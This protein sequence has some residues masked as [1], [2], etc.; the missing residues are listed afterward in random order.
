MEGMLART[1]VGSAARELLR[2]LFRHQCI[3]LDDE[4]VQALSGPQTSAGLT[5]LA[6]EVL[7]VAEVFP[8]WLMHAELDFSSPTATSS[9]FSCLTATAPRAERQN[10]A[11]FLVAHLR[12]VKEGGDSD[13]FRTLSEFVL[14]RGDPGMAASVVSEVVKFACN[15]A[16]AL[17]SLRNVVDKYRSEESFRSTVSGVVAHQLSASLKKPTNVLVALTETFVAIEPSPDAMVERLFAWV[18]QT[19]LSPPKARRTELL[20]LALKL[21]GVLSAFAIALSVAGQAVETMMDGEDDDVRVQC[22]SSCLS[23]CAHHVRADADENRLNSVV[24]KVVTKLL[25]T[26][27]AD[28]NDDVRRTVL[29]ALHSN[30]QLDSH[31]VLPDPLEC[32]FMAVHDSDAMVSE[33]ALGICCRLAARNPSIVVPALGRVELRLMRDL[34]GGV[35][36]MSV[37]AVRQLRVM[38]Q[39]NRVVTAAHVVESE[40]FDKFGR[41]ATFGLQCHLFGLIST[42][43]QNA[44]PSD[45]HIDADALVSRC[46]STVKNPVSVARRC[47]ASAALACVVR[48][49]P[50]DSQ[51]DVFRAAID[52]VKST[53][54]EDGSVLD[55]LSQVVAVIGAVDPSR[56]RQWELTAL[57]SQ[58]E[59]PTDR[60]ELESLRPPS[61][62]HPKLAFQNASVSLFTLVKCMRGSSTFQQR[63]LVLSIGELIEAVGAQQKAQLAPHLLPCLL[64]WLDANQNKPLHASIL[65][66]L[67]S[68]WEQREGFA[69]QLR[70]QL[71]DSLERYSRTVDLNNRHTVEHFILLL[72]QIVRGAPDDVLAHRW[73]A[74]F[75]LQRLSEN[76]DGEIAARA[77]DALEASAVMLGNDLHFTLTQ[78]L[79]CLRSTSAIVINRTLGFLSAVV[80]TQTAKDLCARTIHEVLHMLERQENNAEVD[81][82][83]VAYLCSLLHSVGK[84]AHRFVGLIERTIAA[85]GKS[86]ERFAQFVES[87]RTNNVFP[88]P[89]RYR[90]PTEQAHVVEKSGYFVLQSR[91]TVTEDFVKSC[92]AEVLSV[93][94]SNIVVADCRDLG[95]KG[96]Y[97]RFR[98]DG[99]AP[100]VTQQL[101]NAINRGHTAFAASLQVASFST[102]STALSTKSDV[103]TTMMKLRAWQRL[104]ENAAAQ[105]W[106]SWLV[107]VAVELVKCSEPALRV[108]LAVVRNNEIVA[109]EIFPFAF[110]WMFST[111]DAAHKREAMA[112]LTGA[113]EKCSAEVRQILFSLAEFMESEKAERVITQKNILSKRINVVRQSL[114]DK[115]GIHYERDNTNIMVVKV[116]ENGP[117]GLAKVPVGYALKSIDGTE[118]HDVH[119]IVSLI[120]SRL[121]TTLELQKEQEER[122]VSSRHNEFFNLDTLATVAQQTHLYAKALHYSEMCF[123]ELCEAVAANRREIVQVAD[124]ITNLCTIVGM[125][126]EFHGILR[127]T[128]ETLD[129]DSLMLDGRGALESW[130][131][132]EPASTQATTQLNQIYSAIRK[133]ETVGDFHNIRGV[134]R[135]RKYLSEDIATCCANAAIALSDWGVLGDV[136]TLMRNGPER[137]VATCVLSIARNDA[138]DA[139]RKLI[140]DCR[141]QLSSKFA[142]EVSESYSAAYDSIV[143]LQHLS[144]LEEVIQYK[145]APDGVKQRLHDLWRRRTHGMVRRVQN[146]TVAM[147]INSLV[148][149]P[150][151]DVD[152]LLRYVSLCREAQWSFMAKFTL[153][154]LLKVDNGEQLSVTSITDQTPPRVAMAAFKHLSHG[155]S[156]S[157]SALRA[158]EG[159]VKGS[160]REHFADDPSWC[161][162]YLHLGERF[163]NKGASEEALAFV[164]KA[165]EVDPSNV[166][167]WHAW[168][169]LNYRR[170]H[171]IRDA[172]GVPQVELFV[173]CLEGLLRAI[174]LGEERLGTQDVLRIMSVWFDYGHRAEVLLA[175]EHGIQRSPLAVW[176]R[177][178]PQLIARLGVARRNVRDSLIALVHRVT[179]AFPHAMIYPLTVSQ[180]SA[181]D[182]LRA[183]AAGVALAQIREAW[184]ALVDQA[185]LISAEL[186]RI[187]ILWSEKWS[188]A[189]TRA[190]RM[191]DRHDSRIVLDALAPL[192][193]ELDHPLTS[194]EKAFESH[195]GQTL[196]RAKIALENEPTANQA[197]QFFQQVYTKFN[198]PPRALQLAQVSPKLADL[199]NSVMP[200]PGLVTKEHDVTIATFAQDIVVIPSKHK[201][202]RFSIIASNGVEHRYLLKGHEDLRQDE[203]VMQLFELIN[204]VF[205]SD[206]SSDSM[207]LFVERYAA[208]P[209]SDNV[210]ILGWIDDSE[211]LFKLIDS[212]RNA[213]DIPMLE[214]CNLIMKRGRLNRIDEY[215]GLPKQ[216]RRELLEYVMG[217]TP[218][219]QLRR[220][221][222]DNND[223]CEMWLQYRSTY[224]RSL[225]VMSMVGYVLGLG[226][227]HL[228]NLMIKKNGAIVHID[229]GDC[230]ETAM[231]RE[232]FPEAVPFRLTRMLVRAL[233]VIGV[234]GAYRLTSEHVMRQLRK[235]RDSLQSVLET[236][237]HDPL[238]PWKGV[239][240]RRA[241]TEEMQRQQSSTEQA[242]QW[243]AM[244]E[245][246]LKAPPIEAPAAPLPARHQRK[247]SRGFSPGQSLQSPQSIDG[248]S[249]DVR[250]AQVHAALNHAMAD[251][252]VEAATQIVQRSRSLF[253]QDVRLSNEQGTELRSVDTLVQYFLHSSADVNRDRENA[254]LQRIQSKLTGTDFAELDEMQ[255]SQRRA[256]IPKNDSVEDRVFEMMH[257]F[258]DVIFHR[259]SVG[260]SLN[261]QYTAAGVTRQSPGCSQSNADVLPVDVQVERLISAAR[262]LDNL[263]DAFLTGWAPFL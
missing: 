206:P 104:G 75:A 191:H 23:V 11:S 20:A 204:T 76:R 194:D 79:P 1:D 84:A 234:E 116:A 51:A 235:Y 196:K 39:A 98:I 82:R 246:A 22:A 109:R 217:V 222:W 105:E 253:L 38:A 215:Q 140:R 247:A 117:G 28:P 14:Q 151:D 111:L 45:R 188:D 149:R 97:V 132:K 43:I 107:S 42:T 241:H 212:W 258:D 86:S 30:K 254:I 162:C 60:T 225:A 37:N 169:M 88:E 89:Q 158:F 237:V 172:G 260:T 141:R 119:E 63:S 249:H 94:S 67:K 200:I 190:S 72:E 24:L 17:V 47:A 6:A 142:S 19:L 229:F 127:F 4:H 208:V 56:V 198:R 8:S 138:P 263:A 214:E 74:G 228:N 59:L 10:V 121:S 16:V 34:H 187:A 44:K 125:P 35:L 13:L 40:C 239:V 166:A 27:V 248:V 112:H 78:V 232:Q 220:V 70:Q 124:R 148:L 95:G 167:G 128:R 145:S 102:D 53:S 49:L 144:H 244:F 182:P 92:I 36:S 33:Q 126:H 101:I 120:R 52:A 252:D 83:A 147:S 143:Q 32:L 48:Y 170:G 77:L 202:R 80:Q 25:D 131:E 129:D 185:S 189:L 156:G 251:G 178:I 184:P 257:E 262:S 9:I 99:C 219:D 87:Y 210:G 135:F 68:L 175:V 110:V 209:L 240:G 195:Y 224:A 261:L 243:H 134:A 100:D 255:T 192:Y 203:R 137:S 12:E 163:M 50:V 5:I 154:R 181:R 173:N 114:N 226:D 73:I 223:S 176:L 93:S 205:R 62:T 199:K 115:F 122:V 259:E 136:V 165:T 230:F 85:S 183:E 177:V 256:R 71:L 221:L 64:G 18:K 159:Y 7:T 216:T 161:R 130:M 61:R 174:E 108:A 90:R 233:G 29:E 46:L 179:E 180:K 123:E 103:R 118:V 21:V 250:I 164:R 26:A 213:H 152:S 197:W 54:R 231:H 106:M 69:K 55:E 160:A 193:S 245:R 41:G 171:E 66:L 139:S 242:A 201:P 236:F 146:W 186:V 133:A 238:V 157:D 2:A 227:R 58:Q 155:S 15:D 218:S 96:T 207:S 168:G 113:F 91:A 57:G 31:L 153:G 81:D 211:T 150:E 65:L 3:A